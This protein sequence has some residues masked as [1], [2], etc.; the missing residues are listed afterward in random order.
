LRLL[1][2]TTRRH[3]FDHALAQRGNGGRVRHGGVPSLREV[4]NTSIL[5]DGGSPSPYEL[6]LRRLPGLAEQPPRAAAIAAAI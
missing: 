2:E 3:V 4:D 6:L 1:P 5:K